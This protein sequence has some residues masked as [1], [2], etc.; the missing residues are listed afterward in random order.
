MLFVDLLNISTGE[1]A[2]DRADKSAETDEKN[3]VMGQVNCNSLYRLPFTTHFIKFFF[4]RTSFGQVIHVKIF[5]LG[6]FKRLF[7]FSA[8]NFTQINQC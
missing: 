6:N 7:E 3:I 2:Q 4:S 5:H 8:H 1:I